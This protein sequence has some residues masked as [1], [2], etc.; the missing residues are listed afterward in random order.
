MT[1]DTKV[2]IVHASLSA[3]ILVSVLIVAMT[4]GAEL[5]PAFKNWL[6]ASFSHHWIGKGVISFIAYFVL[7]ALTFVLPLGAH[8]KKITMHLWILFW[9]SMASTL[10]IYLFFVYEAFLK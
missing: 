10:T 1:E 5:M 7:F 6:K 9:V 2:K 8:A 3:A 4:I